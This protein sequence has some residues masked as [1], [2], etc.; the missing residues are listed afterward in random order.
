MVGGAGHVGLP[1]AVLLAHKGMRVLIND[2]NEA[3]MQRIAKGEVPFM[4]HGAEPLLKEVLA[5]GNLDFSSEESDIG[6]APVVIITI[7]TPVDEFQNPVFKLIRKCVDG[8]VQYLSSNQL[9]ILR[10]TV[11]PGTTEW[12]QSYFQ[13][14]GKD[15]RVAF[16]PE[17]IVQ[18]YA[19]KELQVLPQIVSGTTESAARE[20]SDLFALIAPKIVHL[21]PAEAEFAKLFNNAYRYIQFAA[22]NQFYMIARNAG[23]NYH[24]VLKG[25]KID[26]PRAQDIPRP[27][28]AAGPCLQKDTLQLMAFSDNQFSIGY[29]AMMVNEGMVMYIVTRIERQYP[30]AQMTIGLLGMAFKAESDDIR[31]SLS[32]KLKKILEFRARGVMTTDPYVDTDSDLDTLE[33]VVDGSDLLIVCAPHKVYKDLDTKGKPVVDIWGLLSDEESD[34]L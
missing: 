9:V 16:C 31:S 30:L 12:L 34:G 24:R 4:E 17:R 32:Y 25:M 33:A 3:I 19:I 21:E 2:I 23:V 26:Y 1:L 10:S 6:K 28:F 13:S 20:A 11:Y 7:G 15:V 8:F 14:R 29:A 22:A 18:G 5:N 27:G